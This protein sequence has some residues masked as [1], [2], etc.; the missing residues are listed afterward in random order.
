MNRLRIIF[1]SL[2]VLAT[3]AGA[4]PAASSLAKWSRNAAGRHH[5]RHR[6]HSRA[7]WRRHRALMRARR[8]RAEQRRLSGNANAQAA[9]T[10]H[11]P[12]TTA[13]VNASILSFSTPAV[14]GN[15]ASASVAPASVA[16]PSQLP[17]DFTPPQTWTPVRRSRSGEAVF[18][19]RTPDGRPAGTAVVAPVSLSSAD[20]SSVTMTAKTKTVGGVALAALRRTVINRMVAEGGWVTNDFVQESQGRRVFVV[21]AQTGTPGAPAQSWTFY[22]TEIDGRVYSL[23]TTTP[24]EFAEPVAAGSEQFLASLRSA[25]GKNLASQK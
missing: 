19:V 11:S 20:L 4:L 6:R 14:S 7:W 8:A 24:V 23:A 5:R 18:A 21:L 13:A 9:A 2:L 25:G 1:L 3:I 15:S 12:R 16:R 22:F 10:N 17:F